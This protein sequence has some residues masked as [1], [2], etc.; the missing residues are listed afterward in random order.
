MVTGKKQEKL[1]SLI[2]TWTTI[3][4]TSLVFASVHISPT[5]VIDVLTF[6]VELMALA[7]LWGWLIRKPDSIWVS[8]MIHAGADVLAIMD[9][10][11]EVNL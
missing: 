10:L 6:M 3:I 2:G 7:L 11:A 4:I 9:F 5:Y 1:E 8:V